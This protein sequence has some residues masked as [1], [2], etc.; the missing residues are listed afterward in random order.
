MNQTRRH[1]SRRRRRN[2]KRIAANLG[3]ITRSQL[4]RVLFDPIVVPK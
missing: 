4:E 1:V 2:A 3:R